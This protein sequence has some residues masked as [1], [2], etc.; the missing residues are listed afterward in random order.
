[1]AVGPEM[2]LPYAKILGS[3]LEKSV[4]LSPEVP[5]LLGSPGS[6][7]RHVQKSRGGSMVPASHSLYNPLEDDMTKPKDR[8][9]AEIHGR[10][11]DL[12]GQHWSHLAVQMWWALKQGGIFIERR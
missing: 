10:R 3:M 11:R 9:P 12:N 5:N 7:T 8:A 6:S 4:M 2:Q 1:M